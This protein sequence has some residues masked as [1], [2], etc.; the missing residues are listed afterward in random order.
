MRIL[1][2]IPTVTGGGAERQAGYLCR[3]LLRRG[4]DVLVAYLNE[5]VAPWQ[6]AGTPV[7]K[8]AS[9]SPWDPRL[10]V[11]AAR[12]IRSWRPD[13]VQTWIL[14]MDV[15]GGIAAAMTRTPWVLREPTTGSYYAPGLKSWLRLSVARAAVDA[16]V[17]NSQGGQAYWSECAPRVPIRVISNAVPIAE[18]DRAE[19]LAA[20]RPFG[21][22]AGRL[23]SLKN[24]DVA[25]GAAADVMRDR[26]LD[27]VIAGD[28]PDRERLE[29]KVRELGI[30]GRVRFA[31]FTPEVWP[32]MKSAAFFVS[33]SDLEGSPNAVLEA[34][35]AG[36]PAILSDI[37]AHREIA[38]A[39][40]AAFVPLRDVSATAGVMRDVLTDRAAAEA[41]AHA[42][43]LRVESFSVSGMTDAY[44]GVYRELAH[45]RRSRLDYRGLG[46]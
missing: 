17:V 23:E 40:T 25:L 6:R 45:G 3:E 8:L 44:E 15:V 21:L 46:S 4:H 1:H 26:D 16:V 37:P 24:V 29:A 7:V 13:V 31:G 42:A 32:L 5:G 19:G 33:L 12:L 35:A 39:S 36:A 2:F 30:G 34:F 18:I 11:R 14:Q 22:F 41:R 27:L 43:R 20:K 28:G 9:A 38:D 10:L